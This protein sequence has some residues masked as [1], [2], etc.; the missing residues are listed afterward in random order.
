MLGFKCFLSPSG[1]DEFEHVSE[2]DLREA[3]PVLATL[4]LPLLAHA[5]LPAMLREPLDA[6]GGS[7][8]AAYATWLATAGPP[9]SEHAAIALLVAAGA[10]VRRA[11]AHRPSG[12]GRRRSTR[13]PRARRAV[14]PITVETCPHYLTF[15]AEEIADGATA[16]K[17]A[18]PIRGRRQP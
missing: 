7:A 10:R 1:V 13:S 6:G 8:V 17:C 12:V 5:E 11:H 4:G 3:L 16:F 9:A 15:A 18:P 14:S 2:A